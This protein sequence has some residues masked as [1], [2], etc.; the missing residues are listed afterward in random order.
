MGRSKHYSTSKNSNTLLD[1]KINNNIT[2]EKN[3]N[4]INNQLDKLNP[5]YISGLTQ[6]D[7]SFSCGIS[8]IKSKKGNK[9]RFRPKFDL[10]LDK[11]SIN[12][13]N[14][15]KQYFGCG[16]ITNE[17][18]DRSVS[19]IVS[20]LKDLKN[21]IIPHFF[22]YPVFFNKL[23]AFQLLVNI[24]NLMEDKKEYR[25]NATILRSAISMNTASRRTKEQINILYSIIGIS[26][27]KILPKIPYNIKTITSKVTTEFIAGMIDPIGE[28]DLFM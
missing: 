1:L 24:V 18:P 11:D 10:C 27:D 3:N 22:N 9:L 15:I 5:N 8:I 7:G 20:N 6:S 19:F 16:Q 21:I 2:N 12:A 14:A 13:L 28:M 26:F 4:L 17:Q 23:H 25:D